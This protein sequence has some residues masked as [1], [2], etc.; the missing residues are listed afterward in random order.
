MLRWIQE[1][2]FIIGTIY[3]RRQHYLGFV[4]FSWLTLS[5]LFS[6]RTLSRSTIPSITADYLFSQSICN[7]YRCDCL[8][9]D[10]RCRRM[11][12]RLLWPCK[13]VTNVCHR[14]L[15]YHKVD[16]IKWSVIH[17][18]DVLIIN[19]IVLLYVPQ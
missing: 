7:R 8:R 16:L 13:D 2:C 18:T 14:H 9:F 11:T 10:T 17:K 1:V 4:H 5:I 6:R 12:I 19:G 15:I 3:F